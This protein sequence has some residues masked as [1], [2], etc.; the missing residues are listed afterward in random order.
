MSSTRPCK[1]RL[2]A[3]TVPSGDQT[4]RKKASMALLEL[5][6]MA[7]TLVLLFCQVPQKSPLYGLVTLEAV[8]PLLTLGC[9]PPMMRLRL[10][11]ACDPATMW[12]ASKVAIR[13]SRFLAAVTRAAFAV[14][15]ASLRSS[16]R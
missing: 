4:E 5:G 6:S 8:R 15:A 2:V 11:T 1:N 3:A 7:E 13:E 9:R 14:I 12:V 16:Q 10:T